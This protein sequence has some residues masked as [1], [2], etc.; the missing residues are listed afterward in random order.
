MRF[1]SAVF[2]VE[3]RKLHQHTAAVNQVYL[4][5][6][7]RQPAPRSNLTRAAQSNIAL[8]PV[9]ESEYISCCIHTLLLVPRI[10]TRTYPSAS[11]H[12]SNDLGCRHAACSSLY[13]VQ[14]LIPIEPW[15]EGLGDL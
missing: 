5:A 13:L 2:G 15:N 8:V 14:E 10:H 12:A 4:A 1:S 11:T 7:Q 3:R 6:A 9:A